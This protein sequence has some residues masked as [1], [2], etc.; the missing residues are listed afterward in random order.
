VKRPK[1]RKYIYDS[2]RNGPRNHIQIREYINEHY[3]HGIG[4][5]QLVAL[6]NADPNIKAIG[7]ERAFERTRFYNINIYKLVTV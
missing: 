7:T 2:L 5:S 4:R 6:M 3:K 1:L